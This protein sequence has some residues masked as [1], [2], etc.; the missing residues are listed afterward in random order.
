[1]QQSNATSQLRQQAIASCQIG[2]DRAAGTVTALN[3]LILVLEGPKPTPQILAI[4]ANLQQ[5]ILSS[6]QQRDCSKAYAPANGGALT[7]LPCR[8]T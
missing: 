1:M 8:R 7:P 2:N 6:N 3:D 4:A 5:K